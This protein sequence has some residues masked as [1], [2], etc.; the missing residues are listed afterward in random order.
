[1]T[2]GFDGYLRVWVVIV[3]AVV[4]VRRTGR[5]GGQETKNRQCFAA[6]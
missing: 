2:G 5:G 3:I 6:T 1:M 4:V